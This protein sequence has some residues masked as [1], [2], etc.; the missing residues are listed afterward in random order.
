MCI[1]IKLY[2]MF[3][4]ICLYF[5]INCITKTKTHSLIN[6]TKVSCVELNKKTVKFILSHERNSIAGAFTV[7]IIITNHHKSSH[8]L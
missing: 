5:F 6:I 8:F 2:I 7:K 3:S 4:P 1:Y